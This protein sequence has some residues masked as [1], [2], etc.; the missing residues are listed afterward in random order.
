[1]VRFWDNWAQAH[2]NTKAI[3]ALIFLS[4]L[5]VWLVFVKFGQTSHKLEKRQT[6]M[7]VVKAVDTFSIRP[8]HTKY[9]VTEGKLAYKASLVLPDGNAL[10]MTFTNHPPRQ[11]EKVP[12]IVYQ[13]S[14]G[15]TT[16]ELD[17]MKWLT[18]DH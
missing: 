12:I 14:D 9:G 5:F 8:I 17:K 2:R 6:A 16:Y 15:Q 11:G 7:A 1:M 10:T 4:C 18:G 3:F 13:Y